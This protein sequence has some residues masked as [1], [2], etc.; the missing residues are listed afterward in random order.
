MDRAPL[1][2]LVHYHLDVNCRSNSLLHRLHWN[3]LVR[4]QARS[5]NRI[6]IEVDCS[7]S[8]TILWQPTPQIVHVPIQSLHLDLSSYQE[9]FRIFEGYPI[10]HKGYDS[11]H[12]CAYGQ[13]DVEVYFWQGYRNGYVSHGNCV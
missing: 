4:F 1:R 10:G 13:R 11:S 2:A 9:F 6:N 12:D 7:A 8:A 3:L 5:S